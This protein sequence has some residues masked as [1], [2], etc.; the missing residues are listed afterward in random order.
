[1]NA[2]TA[3]QTPVS[4]VKAAPNAAAKASVPKTSASV[5]PTPRAP[6]V[7]AQVKRVEKLFE[8]VFRV[9]GK[10]A[11]QNA[12]PGKTVYGEKLIVMD[13]VEYRL[14]EPSRSKI[15]AALVKGLKS[16]AIKPGSKVL[17][18]GAAN[19]TTVSH[20]SDIV[21][22]TGAVFGVEFSARSMR[23]LLKLA[24][25]RD[26]IYPIL[27]DARNPDVYA[28]DVGG[29]ESVDVVFEDVADRAQ[30]Q[31][32]IDNSAS[33]LKP[34]GV[35]YIAIK[36]RSIDAKR[37]PRSVFQ[38]VEKELAGFF[39]LQQGLSLEPFEADHAFLALSRK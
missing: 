28:G 33:M 8:G 11:T 13:N 19:G 23:D 35:A 32:L 36:S 38:Q 17:Y 12:K 25:V 10:L 4:P 14:W 29:S 39:N 9:D 2:P 37:A 5:K 31:I 22:P 7:L 27:A 26:N 3:R 16:F 6:V 24:E 18:L 15:A 21:G 30:S 1:M 20:V 34:N